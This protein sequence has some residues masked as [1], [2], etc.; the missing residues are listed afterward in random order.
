M[1][2]RRKEGDLKGFEQEEEGG[3]YEDMK[4]RKEK[5]RKLNN[6]S[7]RKR[8]GYEQK[9]EEEREKDMNKG[10]EIREDMN[11]RRK[12]RDKRMFTGE[13]RQRYM[14]RRRARRVCI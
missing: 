12:E 5:E 8:I 3:R 4:K 1:N 9:T 6:Y 14:T 13:G 10:K 11:S 2:R 7:R